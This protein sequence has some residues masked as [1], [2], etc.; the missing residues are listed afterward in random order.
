MPSS[1]NLL[2]IEIFKLMI[3]YCF[4]MKCLTKGCERKLAGYALRN[5]IHDSYCS[6]YC[7][8]SSER[9]GGRCHPSQSI[10]RTCYVCDETFDLSYP[11][12]RANQRTC[13]SRCQLS[14]DKIKKG[15]RNFA[16]LTIIY[17]LAQYDS[18]GLTAEDIAIRMQRYPNNIKGA[19][20]ITQILK[21]FVKRGMVV[22]RYEPGT[23]LK[24]FRWSPD[25]Q[26]RPG[27][28]LKL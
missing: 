25:P 26:L 27:H 7:K 1:R 21:P 2:A 20:G 8:L 22:S 6:L 15:R 3:R 16:I 4:T 18:P 23:K 14:I 28:L 11:Y 19:S 9:P 5:K 17:E 12:N 10:T 13:S 24:V